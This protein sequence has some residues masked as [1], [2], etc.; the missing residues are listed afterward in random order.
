MALSF[1][2]SFSPVGAPRRPDSA[3]APA[4]Q[5]ATPAPA[6]AERFTDRRSAPAVQLSLSPQA[7]AVLNGGPPP[8]APRAAAPARAAGFEPLAF[9]AADSPAEETP[10]APRSQQA[11]DIPQRPQRPGSRLD[12]KL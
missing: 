6:R 2:T 10:A 9:P 3:P 11:A 5:P 7:L 12:I 8:Q 1:L 4:N